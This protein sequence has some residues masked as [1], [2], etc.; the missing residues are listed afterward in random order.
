MQNS[1]HSDI[2]CHRQP[3]S[4]HFIV[5]TCALAKYLVPGVLLL[6][7]GGALERGR[8]WDI[9]MSLWYAL[10]GDYG[11]LTP[12]RPF[13]ADNVMVCS[14]T[15]STSSLLACCRSEVLFIGDDLG[16]F[17]VMTEGKP[18]QQLGLGWVGG[19]GG[20]RL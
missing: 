18:L 8:M 12:S 19:A 11:F 2:C 17:V 3:L 20:T 14:S 1:A 4:S 16:N 7:S 6:G 10:K 15:Y 9:F 5:V 13:L